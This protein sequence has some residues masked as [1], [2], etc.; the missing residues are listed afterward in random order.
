MRSLIEPPGFWLSS[1][2]NSRHGPV[3]KPGQLDHRRV[4]DQVVAGDDLAGA[5]TCPAAVLVGDEAAGLAHHQD[6]G[7]HVPGRQ[8]LL[9]EA[10]EA[11]RRRPRRGRARPSRSGG[12]RRPSA[13]HV[14]QLAEV[15]AVMRRGRDA[16]CRCRSRSR[17]ARCAP[18]TRRRRSL[19]QAPPP[20]SAQKSSSVD[21]IVDHAGDDLRPARSSAIEMAK[22]GMPCRK[23]VVPSSGSTIQ[24]CWPSV[25]VDRA[26]LLHQ[27]AV[28]R[29]R[30][31][32]VRRRRSARP[33]GRLG[34][35]VGRALARDLQV[36]DLAE[37]A[38]A[39]RAP[40][41]GRPATMTLRMGGG[42]PCASR[43]VRPAHV[44]DCR[45]CR[46]RCARPP[47]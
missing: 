13:H 8:R 12:C 46:R 22:C 18:A 26:A 10:V 20:F 28:A 31:G 25:P 16:A 41:C 17:P 33:C 15:A 27:E 44:G 23:L 40:P 47:R 36:L 30:L 4:A 1:L 3:S 37:V 35:E 11:A 39:A 42:V 7:R 24:R 6:A 19:S 2:T 14:A 9:P 21:R 38:R 29:P 43:S 32:A 5:R 34:D 45:R